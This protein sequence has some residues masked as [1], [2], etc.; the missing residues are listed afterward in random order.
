MK[1]VPA[2]LACSLALVSAAACNGGTETKKVERPAVELGERLFRDPDL[3]PSSNNYLACNDCHSGS[4][5][6]GGRI[7]AGYP[8]ENAAT[9][10]AWWG[11]YEV[12]FLD[13]VNFCLT[14][15]MRGQ[16]LAP[17]DPEGDALYEFLDSISPVETAP[18]LPLTLTKTPPLLGGGDAD[19]GRDVWDAACRDCHGSP[20]GSGRLHATVTPLDADLFDEYDELFPNVNHRLI[21]AEKVRHGAFFG[22]GGVM[23]PF[24]EERLTDEQLAD[25]M[26]YLG[27]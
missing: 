13:A 18:A 17:G 5:D 16:R 25:V 22:I 10:E 12:Q 4:A 19:E 24:A 11:G 27:L 14:F 26:A 21:V 8:L 2:I 6:E 1:R 20:S 9:R 23:P 3:S 7:Y 15:F